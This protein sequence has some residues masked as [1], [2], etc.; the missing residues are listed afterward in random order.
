MISG[1]IQV[2]FSGLKFY[3][4]LTLCSVHYIQQE[5]IYYF[6]IRFISDS[7]ERGIPAVRER[8]PVCSER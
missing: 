3:H 2:N 5:C 7:G 1:E 6:L 8:A 4:S